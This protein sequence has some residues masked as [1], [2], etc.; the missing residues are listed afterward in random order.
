[1][2]TAA[3]LFVPALLVAVTIG[4]SKGEKKAGGIYAHAIFAVLK[5]PAVLGSRCVAAPLRETWRT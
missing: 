4:C 5:S 2:G 3:I 1:M